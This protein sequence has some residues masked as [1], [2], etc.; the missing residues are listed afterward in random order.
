M[1]LGLGS[2]A[3]ARA[4]A[5]GTFDAFALLAEARRLGLSAVQYADNLPLHTLS[6]ADLDRLRN[7][8]VKAGIEVEVG[9]RGIEP[10]LLL[11]YAQIAHGFGATFVRTVIDIGEDRPSASEAVARLKPTVQ[12]MAKQDVALAIEN[13]DRFPVRVLA[14]M[15]E[16][17]GHGTGVCLDTANSL[18]CLEGTETVVSVLAPHTLSLHLK[19][20]TVRRFPDQMGFTVEGTAAGEGLVDCLA[21]ARTV[22]A[23]GRNPIATLELWPPDDVATERAMRE[24]SVALLLEPLALV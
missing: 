16:E 19:D 1:K 20:V 11:R 3:C 18:G 5:T 8:A 21:V 24:R 2:F 7:E 22:V 4:I 23:A 15:V 10:S 9:T 12:E 6:A 17:L 13:H 14:S